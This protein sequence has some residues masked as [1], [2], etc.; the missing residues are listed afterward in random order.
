MVNAMKKKLMEYYQKLGKER[1]F[2]VTCFAGFL[3]IL[4]CVTLNA[5]E[6]M[7]EFHFKKSPVQEQANSVLWLGMKV[8]PISRDIRSEFKIPAK[9][10]GMFVSDA[11]LGEALKRG[12]TTGDVICTINGKKFKDMKSFV[13]VAE[14][15]RYYDGILLDVFRNGKNVYISVPF[16]YAYGPVMGPNQGRWQLGSP[17][18]KQILPYGQARVM[19]NINWTTKEQQ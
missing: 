19:P 16:L 11:G 17:L 14:Q 4:L 5:L 10:K 2:Y 6:I 8:A 9:V 12:V 13:E 18:I 15:S 7:P 3:V 1:A